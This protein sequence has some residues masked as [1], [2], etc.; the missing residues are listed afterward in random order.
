MIAFRYV[1][2]LDR[3]QKADIAFAD[4]IGQIESVILILFRDVDD[5]AQIRVD[6]FVFCRLVARFRFQRQIGFL[7]ARK[8]RNFIDIFQIH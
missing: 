4:Q 7:V 6:D 3:R 2:P 1:E 5:K 8:Q